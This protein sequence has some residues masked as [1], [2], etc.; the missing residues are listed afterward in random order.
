M[1]TRYLIGLA[2]LCTA[3]IVFLFS[4]GGGF[5]ENTSNDFPR[6]GVIKLSPSYRINERPIE[7][8]ASGRA[9]EAG[10]SKPEKIRN[11]VEFSSPEHVVK[12]QKKLQKIGVLERADNE[13]LFNI[14]QIQ[15]EM[16][17]IINFP[18]R[19]HYP[20]SYFADS[21]WTYIWG[22]TSSSPQ[23]GYAI[24]MNTGNIHVWKIY[25][26]DKWDRHLTGVQDYFFELKDL[27]P[28]PK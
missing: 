26:S 22:G 9:G 1:K 28:I 21:G 17:P 25:D 16:S 4:K 10:E 6:D 18:I 27:K 12:I 20:H 7:N 2:L 15:Q 5:E 24:E 3:L 19:N 13:P 14:T 11:Y 23:H 8:K